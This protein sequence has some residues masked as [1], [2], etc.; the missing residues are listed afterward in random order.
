MKQTS[1]ATLCISLVSC[2]F[3]RAA[4]TSLANASALDMRFLDFGHRC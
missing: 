3:F 2:R 1:V 4:H